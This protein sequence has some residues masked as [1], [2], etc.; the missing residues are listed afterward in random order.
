[1]LDKNKSILHFSKPNQNQL[2]LTI[3]GI[4]AKNTTDDIDKFVDDKYN[5]RCKKCLALIEG[6][7]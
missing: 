1:M 7:K 3:H 5:K 4:W 2:Y 6:S